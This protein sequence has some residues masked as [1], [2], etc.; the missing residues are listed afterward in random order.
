LQKII[1]VHKHWEFLILCSGNYC[2]EIRKDIFFINKKN[3]GFS[4]VG[5]LYPFCY[6]FFQLLIEKRII[7][8]YL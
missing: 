6:P 4:M 5:F 8:E 1:V 7:K 3:F 2:K